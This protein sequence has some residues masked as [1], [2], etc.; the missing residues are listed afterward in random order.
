MTVLESGSAFSVGRDRV[1]M[2]L[3]SLLT[4]SGID[5]TAFSVDRGR[6]LMSLRSLLT[7][8]EYCHP[9]LC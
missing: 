1:L 8:V 9:V 6:V 2:S 7:G 5:V 4:G 3:R